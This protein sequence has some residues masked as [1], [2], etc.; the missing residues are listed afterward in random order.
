MRGRERESTRE[1]EKKN[2]R[3]R[4]RER[5]GNE[6]KRVVNEGWEIKLRA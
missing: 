5:G 6:W 3:G 4:G 2:E 1:N